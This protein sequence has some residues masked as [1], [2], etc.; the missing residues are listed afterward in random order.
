MAERKPMF[1]AADG[2][3]EEMA[4]ADSM[5]L[6]GLTMGGN[7]IMAA[8]KITGLGA[9]SASGDALAYGQSSASLAGL[10]LTAD[11]AMGTNGISGLE[12]TPSGANYAASKAYVDS[13]IT[14]LGWKSPVDVF[15]LVGNATPTALNALGA[16]AGAAYVVITAPGTLTRGS[17]SVAIGD[18]VEDDGTNWVMIQANSGGFVPVGIRAILSGTDTL[19]A[20]YTDA[21]DNDKIVEFSG[22]SN[23]GADTGDAVDKAAVLIQ[24]PGHVGYYDNNGYVYEGTVPTGSWVQFTG[25]GTINAG[26]GLSK[27]GNTLDVNMGDGITNASDY[28][29]IDLDTNPGLQLLGTTPAKKL[30]ALADTTAGMEI[31]ASGIAIDL[32]ATPGLQ[33]TGG[34]LDLLLSATGALE[35]S[36]GLSVKVEASNPTL[37][38]DGS[39]QLGVKYDTLKG[40][41]T[42][43]LGLVV[44]VDGSSVT[45]DGS[46][47]LQVSGV[48]EA[49]KIENTLA[50]S[51]AVAA[52]DPVYWNGTNDQVGK[53]LANDNAK[54][55]VMGV[56]R[57]AQATPGQTAEVV[58]HGVLT[59]AFAGATVGTPYYLQAAG[60]IGTS[61]P[62]AGNRVILVGYAKN[63]TDL[64]VQ[65]IDYGKKAA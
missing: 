61:V 32:A 4:I 36:A 29:A 6:G 42:S 37:A 49:T 2:F 20:P 30:S 34:D 57:T 41:G 25:A 22:S 9:A 8:N 18:L 60:G 1:M 28:V 46:G 54:A 19:L 64:W 31:T 63:A 33:F 13:L 62:G 52:A 15:R 16:N 14:G 35:K 44:K 48:S 51:E 27:T 12:T 10:T 58:S 3:S 17:L 39:N 38:I 26:A 23:T 43:A 5:T 7:V 50:V 53:A 21:T 11:L 47:Q 55:R 65:I 45:F 56:A 24:D 40:L 59:T